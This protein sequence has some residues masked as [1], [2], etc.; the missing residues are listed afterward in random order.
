MDELDDQLKNRIKEVFDNFEDPSA[1]E[2]WLL[3]REKFPEKRDRRGAFIWKWWGAAALVL[4]LLGI[5]LWMRTSPDRREN[6]IAKTINQPNREKLIPQKTI[7]DSPVNNN[8]A[9]G[10]KTN[11]VQ[12]IQNQQAVL[13]QPVFIPTRPF[14]QNAGKPNAQLSMT[15]TQA[16]HVSIVQNKDDSSKSIIGKA[17]QVI[18]NNAPAT[19]NND[20][21][22][23]A[24]HPV[25]D[26]QKPLVVQEKKAEKNII[27]MFKDDKGNNTQKDDDEIRSR[28][29]RF[30]VYAATYFNYS[31]GS[32]NQMNVGAGITSD[33]PLTNNLKLVTGI[34]VAQ[35]SL[36]YSAVPSAVYSSANA[37]FVPATFASSANAFMA[38]STPT[39]KNY[40]ASL[41]GLDIPVNLKY[42]FNPQKTDAYFSL[43]LSSG[44][45]INETYTYKYNYPLLASESLQQTKDETTGTKFNNFYF[46]KMLN[47]A[48][49]IGYPFGK[50]RLVIEPFLKYPLDGMGSQNLRFGSGGLNLKFNFLSQPTHK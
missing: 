43:G 20:A 15:D 19:S 6:N 41:V 16:K 44:T 2:G 50:N 47:V 4:V 32:S 8:L 18:A 14:S 11:K 27:A 17:P 36:S 3:L 30:G 23:N 42:E 5:F 1:D 49:G 25:K 31:K 48:F 10:K 12:S 28:K 46:A 37:R 39:V 38:L 21:S 7:A 45:F 34:S 22:V 40:N 35:N 9:P 26:N 29:I 24:M 13:V 33:I